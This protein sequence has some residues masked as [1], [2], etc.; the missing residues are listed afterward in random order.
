MGVSCNFSL[1]PPNWPWKICCLFRQQLLQ[2]LNPLRWI[3][4]AHRGF[5]TRLGCPDVPGADWGIA[6]GL[7]K[8]WWNHW[9]LRFHGEKLEINVDSL[10]ME[11]NKWWWSSGWWF[12]PIWKILVTWDDYSQS[13]GKKS[14][15]PNHQPVMIFHRPQ[16]D[17]HVGKA[18]CYPDGMVYSNHFPW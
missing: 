7:W 17:F 16:R 5:I 10:G 11:W 13:M 9:W 12:Q 4:L 3:R 1:K 8:S 2:G 18:G 15:V 6:W 14:H